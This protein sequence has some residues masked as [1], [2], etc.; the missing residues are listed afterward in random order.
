MGKLTFSELKVESLSANAAV[1]LGKFELV[2][3]KEKDDKKM[4]ARGRFTLIMKKFPDGWKVVHDHTS[5]E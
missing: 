4:T 5:A 3:E 1:V 2:F